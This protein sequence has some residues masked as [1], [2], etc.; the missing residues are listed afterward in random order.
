M[1]PS[2][3]SSTQHG[4]RYAL[5][6]RFYAPALIA[7]AV[8]AVLFAAAHKLPLSH[9]ATRHCASIARLWIEPRRGA[10]AQASHF[11]VRSHPAPRTQA[12][13]LNSQSL[14]N[15]ICSGTVNL[16]SGAC[17]AASSYF[18][19]PARAPPSARFSV[20]S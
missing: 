12:L 20:L 13:C 15:P 1:T 18:L 11:K 5:G 3:S 10:V 16:A 7:L 14:H 17:K 6:I 4:N 8:S 2:Y 9:H 19:I